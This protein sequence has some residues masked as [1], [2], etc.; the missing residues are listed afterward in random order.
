MCWCILYMYNRSEMRACS[1]SNTIWYCVGFTFESLK[2]VD[3][4][5]VFFVR[6]LFFCSFSIP[7]LFRRIW[8]RYFDS[9]LFLLFFFFALW[10]F[11]AF[12]S[13]HFVFSYVSIPIKAVSRLLLCKQKHWY[14][15]SI[16]ITLILIIDVCIRT[17]FAWCA[18]CKPDT[19][20]AH[21]IA[22]IGMTE[23]GER[24]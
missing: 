6:R 5:F 11:R 3:I 7:L 15:Y 1:K 17:I 10:M 16:G 20:R 13:L 12:F 8:Q 4:S 21:T 22:D 18:T 23:G 19:S 9:L 24:F 14:I 2:C